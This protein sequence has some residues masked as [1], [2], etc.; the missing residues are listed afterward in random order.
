MGH[1]SL[2]QLRCTQCLWTEQVQDYSG[3]E[4]PLP[5]CPACGGVVRPCVVL[6]D[7]MLPADAKA[8]YGRELDRGF[9]LVVS[10][11]TSSL[12]PYITLPIAQAVLRGAR[13][14]EIN[15]GDTSVSDLVDLKIRLGASEALSGL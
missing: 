12:F 6:F 7:E 11:G 3:L 8:L 5:T 9:D 1:G 10:I 14:V 15:P 13:S 4:A 2:E